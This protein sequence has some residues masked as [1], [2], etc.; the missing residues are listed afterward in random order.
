MTPP[1]AGSVRELWVELAEALVAS[2]R[3]H[4]AAVYLTKA[5]E[6]D[7][8]QPSPADIYHRL[9]R[10]GLGSTKDRLSHL[11]K[12]VQ[13]G[14]VDH[15]P[16]E[17][18]AAAAREARQLLNESSVVPD[19][20][21]VET[22][23]GK[24]LA[25]A[26]PDLR[27]DIALLVGLL[28]LASD[29]PTKA[30][31]HLVEA[32]DG[33]VAFEAYLTLARAQERLG[34]DTRE[35][36]LKALEHAP[37]ESARCLTNRRLAGASLAQG[38]VTE[39]LEHLKAV[40]GDLPN[41][42][43]KE[44]I[45]LLKA[46]ALLASGQPAEALASLPDTGSI[47]ASRLEVQARLAIAAQDGTPDPA[48]ADLTERLLELDP[49]GIDSVL[50][51]AQALIESGVDVS[52]GRRLLRGLPE[53]IA[54]SDETPTV[55]RLAALGRTA[56]DLGIA[57]VLTETHAALASISTDDY[58]RERHLEEARANLAPL[59]VL[60]D[61]TPVGGDAPIA[62]G[63]V[64][65]LAAELHAPDLSAEELVDREA[66]AGEA[67]LDEGDA[68][69]AIALLE[70]T[71]A[72]PAATPL[73]TWLLVDAERVR[74]SQLVGA[75]EPGPEA[76]KIVDDAIRL[77]DEQFLREPPTVDRW[78]AYAA[79]ALLAWHRASL[80]DDFP[81]ASVWEAIAFQ[82]VAVLREPYS[83]RLLD[84]AVLLR[85][86]DFDVAAVLVA[87]EAVGIDASPAN[88]VEL[89]LGRLGTGDVA[90]A[91]DVVTQL[92]NVDDH[93]GAIDPAGLD[94]LEAYALRHRLGEGDLQ[95][96]RTL[97]DRIAPEDRDSVAWTV[98]AELKVLDGN[99]AQPA[100]EA[101]AAAVDRSQPF[102]ISNLVA[103][104]VYTGSASEAVTV[105]QECIDRG[106]VFSE[107]VHRWLGLSKL[108]VGDLGGAD[109][110][111]AWVGGARDAVQLERLIDFDLPRLSDDLDSSVVDRLVDAAGE[112]LASLTAQPPR[113]ID[114][115]ATVAVPPP[116]WAAGW[117]R[118]CT[119]MIG[120]VDV[121][122]VDGDAENALDRAGEGRRRRR[123]PAGATRPNR[124]R[125]G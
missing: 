9:G 75:G 15:D 27:D 29:E 53:R 21:Q 109:D 119:A 112:R 110:V 49:L 78:W 1:A 25:T 76:R 52:E 118:L 111:L 34:K 16:A 77:W 106:W 37:D 61:E 124:S 2:E 58:G 12:S 59:M 51:R 82:H 46:A 67:L 98:D 94:L 35:A 13:H 17:D 55:L 42:A 81:V 19:R 43:D 45:E 117:W 85:M 26:P 97:I 101:A 64:L 65:R 32:V 79:R 120:L 89:C 30:V 88:L 96:A 70:V 113:P 50:V 95:H 20:K 10:A 122:R 80:V 115:L 105:A 100:W 68:L 107:D 63:P 24:V 108:A 72:R 22:L 103:S 60:V 7:G 28:E 104:L 11:L 114:D 39:A 57:H 54:R 73:A 92:R 91:I 66:R 74:A 33:D 41:A 62:V 38:M 8:S 40:S 44:A 56:G 86:A 36:L 90:G 99:D 83:T 47:D 5:L 48:V 71:A 125:A 4:E 23:R 18:V 6:E 102:E 93:Q 87:E 14:V 121:R 116:D 69:G 31:S 123:G 84:L 3:E